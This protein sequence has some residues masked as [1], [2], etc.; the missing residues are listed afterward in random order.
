MPL[1]HTYDIKVLFYKLLW[2]KQTS[3]GE[4]KE[5]VNVYLHIK[6]RLRAS[7]SLYKV[8]FISEHNSPIL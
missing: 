7:R 4:A 2:T 5:G 8:F 6:F 3:Y 1:P